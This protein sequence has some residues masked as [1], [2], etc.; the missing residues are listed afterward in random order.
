MNRLCCQYFYI[1]TFEGKSDGYLIKFLRMEIIW[2]L[3]EPSPCIVTQD[4][5]ALKA[6][7]QNSKPYIAQVPKM[8][9]DVGGGR[10]QKETR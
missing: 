6:K 10:K 2:K 8:Y 9:W 4:F 7:F 5:V 3:T 1:G